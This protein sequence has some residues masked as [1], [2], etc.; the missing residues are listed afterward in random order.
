M[1]YIAAFAAG[2]IFGAVGVVVVALNCAPG[3]KEE[4]DIVQKQ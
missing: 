4:D 2:V 3:K 1:G